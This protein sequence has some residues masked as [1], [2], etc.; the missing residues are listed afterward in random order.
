MSFIIKTILA[1]RDRAETPEEREKFERR[2]AE[3][4]AMLSRMAEAQDFTKEPDQ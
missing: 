3:H 4:Q 2:A 1:Q